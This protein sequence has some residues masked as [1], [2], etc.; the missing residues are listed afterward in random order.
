MGK[1][2]NAPAGALAS[3]ARSSIRQP[4]TRRPATELIPIDVLNPAQIDSE[5]ECACV[6]EVR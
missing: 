4:S 6:G 3:P 2:I 1:T 5:R